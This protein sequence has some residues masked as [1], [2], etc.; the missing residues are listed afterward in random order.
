MGLL[1]LGV[2]TL[3]QPSP[4]ALGRWVQAEAH[5]RRK[6]PRARRLLQLVE[7]DPTRFCQALYWA[8]WR[9]GLSEAKKTAFYS[10][11]DPGSMEG[12]TRRGAGMW[13]ALSPYA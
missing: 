7:T 2:T 10:H 5:R 8:L 6:S 11:Y 12:R 1:L 13:T 4:Q 3:P 9:R